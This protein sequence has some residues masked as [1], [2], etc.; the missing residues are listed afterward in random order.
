MSKATG[1]SQAPSACLWRECYGRRFAIDG[2][3]KSLFLKN[4]KVPNS[5]IVIKKAGFKKVSWPG[6]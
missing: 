4:W 3:L 1:R 2:S 6:K 5:K